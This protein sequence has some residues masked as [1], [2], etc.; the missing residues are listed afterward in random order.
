MIERSQSWLLGSTL[1]RPESIFTWVTALA[2]RCS[3]P[4][5]SEQTGIGS[6]NRA[7]RAAPTVE[8]PVVVQRLFEALRRL[9]ADGG[10]GIIRR[11]F[12][13]SK[14]GPATPLRSP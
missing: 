5:R 6:R 12:R 10:A 8:M 14:S 1:R 9:A 4:A 11:G 3:R 2:R 13:R 7:H